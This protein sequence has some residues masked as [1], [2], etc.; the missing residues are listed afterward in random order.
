MKIFIDSAKLGE[1]REAIS[2]GVVHGVTTNPSLLRKAIEE[3]EKKRSEVSLAGYVEEICKVAGKGRPV[4]LEVLSQDAKRMVKEARILYE[5]FNPIAENVVIKIPVNT[6]TGPGTSNTEGLNA[7]GKLSR[8]GISINATL[9][10]T[11]EQALLAAMAGAIY[12]SPFAGRVDDYIRKNLGIDFNKSDYFDFNMLKQVVREKLR[13]HLKNSPSQEL[14]SLYSD[15]QLRKTINFDNNEGV[16]SG[17]DLV[18]RIISIFRN[19]GMKTKVIAASMR[20]PRQVRE[21]AEVGADIATVPFQVIQM[22]LKH[23]KT[24]E[25]VERFYAD[26]M[27]ARYEELFS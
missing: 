6:S 19:Y 15:E 27:S 26:A 12:V 1:I 9:I 13:E 17:V 3:E 4:S 20:N 2:W 18:R 10:M 22:M 21:V 5:K 8:E 7:I 16:I 24:E 25:G 23:P 11:P 14:R